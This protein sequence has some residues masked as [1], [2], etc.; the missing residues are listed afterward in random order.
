[1]FGLVVEKL[2]HVVA[3]LRQYA[4]DPFEFIGSRRI[5]GEPAEIP[6]DDLDER[7]RALDDVGQDLALG[8]CRDDARFKRLVELLEIFFRALSRRDVLED[9]SY[10]AATGGPD[11]ERGEIEIAAGSDQFALKTDGPPGSQYAPVELYPTGCLVG[12]HLPHLLSDDVGNAGVQGIGRVCLDVN[13]VAELSVRPV[14]KLDDAKTFV[15]GLEQGAIALF[16]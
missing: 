13:V 10:L 3:D 7:V 9:H 14:Q 16:A 4:V 6:V 5:D 12:H 1:M 2:E 11:A 15:D 8:K